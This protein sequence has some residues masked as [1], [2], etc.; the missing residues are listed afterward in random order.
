MLNLPSSSFLKVTL[1]VFSSLFLRYFLL[2]SCAVPPSRPRGRDHLRKKKKAGSVGVGLG[3]GVGEGGGQ[4]S[5][6]SLSR[7][8][9]GNRKATRWDFK[10]AVLAAIPAL[11]LLDP[12]A[13]T[14][15]AP[16][17]R[18]SAVPVPPLPRSFLLSFLT[19]TLHYL[20]GR[21]VREVGRSRSAL[22]R[23]SHLLFSKIPA[24]VSAGR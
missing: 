14:P 19:G 20:L 5:D 18:R 17:L 24:Q 8:L 4:D 23:G 13:H 7:P 15:A 11:T 6:C 9:S 22:S 3:V 1:Y 16:F 10:A 2:T 21:H 12:S